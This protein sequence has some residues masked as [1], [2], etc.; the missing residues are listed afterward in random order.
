M[1]F[2]FYFIKERKKK[3]LQL[4]NWFPDPIRESNLLEK[5]LPC[6]EFLPQCTPGQK[7]VTILNVLLLS[8]DIISPHIRIHGHLLMTPT[9]SFFLTFQF[10]LVRPDDSPPGILP[11][12]SEPLLMTVQDECFTLGREICIWGLQLSNP[13]MAR[14]VSHAF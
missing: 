1:F 14:L 7:L 10:V 6:A 12:S 5:S 11:I 9:Y 13:E 8:N 2:H 3:W 4:L